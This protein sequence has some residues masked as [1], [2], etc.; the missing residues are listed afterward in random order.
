[1]PHTR[2]HK[3][4]KRKIK[5]EPEN[6][7][8][9]RTPTSKLEITKSLNEIKEKVNAV[10][11]KRGRGNRLEHN[12]KSRAL[13]TKLMDKHNKKFNLGKY[14][15]NTTPVEKKS[16]PKNIKGED[17]AKTKTDNKA[18]D[19]E[20][21]ASDSNKANVKKTMSGI[22]V[23][24]KDKDTETAGNTLLS[25]LKKKKMKRTMSGFRPR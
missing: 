17:N 3:L 20:S 6:K 18:S 15:P 10:K 5:K 25:K 21:K 13:E 19:T 9:D 11:T 24:G 4:L 1:M 14:K 12:E 7:K 8:T 2:T 16:R 22:T 23:L